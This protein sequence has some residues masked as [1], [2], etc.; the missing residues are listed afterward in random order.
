MNSTSTIDSIDIDA[1]L[2]MEDPEKELKE[3][4]I[5]RFSSFYRNP[6][7]Q[8]PILIGSSKTGGILRE[9]GK[10]L[11]AGVSKAGKSFGLIELAL[12]LA[13]G[14][15]WL[16]FPCNKTTV[17]Y[18]N[19]EIENAEFQN[20]VY[21]VSRKMK[22]CEEDA[23]NLCIWN[24]RGKKIPTKES[25][26]PTTAIIR[27]ARE[28][29]AGMVIIDPIYKLTDANENDQQQVARM[30]EQI[31]R[32][33]QEAETACAIVHHYKKGAGRDYADAMDRASGSGVFARDPDAILAMSP[34]RDITQEQREAAGVSLKARAF[35]IEFTLRSFASPDPIKVWFDNRIH[36]VDNENLKAAKVETNRNKT[37]PTQA[38]KNQRFIESMQK[39]FEENKEMIDEN[40]GIRISSLSGKVEGLD[41]N[42][43][44][45]AKSIRDNTT[46]LNGAAFKV[47]KGIIYPV[48]N[49]K[50]NGNGSL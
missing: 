12:A 46:K 36:K 45:T 27:I 21:H 25:E 9:G 6:P 29:N 28:L 35:Q 32:I 39:A 33:C 49:E 19:M 3:A 47:E 2:G 15:E 26:E 37:R 43:L 31:D 23:K 38:E 30:F 13:S 50:G 22:V 8:K 34:L 18:L 1:L 41:G 44:K 42:P 48:E 17:L 16:G 4:G 24:L 14:S 5:I 10:L 7:P 11:L 20:R 40:G